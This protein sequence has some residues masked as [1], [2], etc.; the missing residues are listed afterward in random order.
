MCG[1]GSGVVVVV[2]VVV[3]MAAVVVVQQRSAESRVRYCTCRYVG[4]GTCLRGL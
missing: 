4:V 1:S 2:V 3:V